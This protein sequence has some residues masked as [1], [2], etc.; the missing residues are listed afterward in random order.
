MTL[1]LAHPF[2]RPVRSVTIVAAIGFGAA[3]VTF[4]AGLAASLTEIQAAGDHGDVQVIGGPH[5]PAG[6][7]DAAAIAATIAAQPG[8]AGSCAVAS[9]RVGVTGLADE[10]ETLA[11]SGQRCSYGYRLVA[12]SWYTGPGQ[13]VVATPFLT[14]TGKRVGDTV[15]LTFEG[16]PV[17]ARIAGEVFDTE[18]D[19]LQILTA[20]ATLGSVE[21][22]QFD[23]LVTAGTDVD[24]YAK[25]LNVA[26]QPLSVQAMPVDRGTASLILTINAL[27]GLLTVLLIVVA[28]LGVLNTVVLETRERV[29]DLGVHKALGMAPR[30]T[31]AMVV[32]SVVVLGVAGGLAG[33][34]AGV[35][36][37]RAIVTRMGDTAGFRL[38][39]SVLDVYRPGQLLLFAAGGLLIAVAG[40]LLPAGWAA[41]TS[42]AAALRTE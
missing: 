27:A 38:P 16:R 41:R 32:A 6:G 4:A 7:L 5:R 10:L 36:L 8:T 33:T 13:I 34:P 22:D 35:L 17:S 18:N 25:A 15:T 1:G 19:G 37:Q 12:G 2:A 23:V 9:T 40:A 20:A 30:Q 28:A 39:A 31:I 42:T 26:L 3:A 11:G 29:H 14:A 24:A 21:P